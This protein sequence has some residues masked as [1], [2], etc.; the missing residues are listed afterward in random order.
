MRPRAPGQRGCG[1]GVRQ[2]HVAEKAAVQV[3]ALKRVV[4]QHAPFRDDPAA[5][6]VEQRARVDDAFAREAAAVK[7]VHI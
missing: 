1:E 6:A 4:A 7:A 2:L 3:C 5:A